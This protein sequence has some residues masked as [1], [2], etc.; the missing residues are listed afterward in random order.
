MK[1]FIIIFIVGIF[2][3]AFIVGKCNN[4]DMEEVS[5]EVVE[6]VQDKNQEIDI[7]ETVVD[8]PKDREQSVFLDSTVSDNPRNL[9]S[10]PEQILV[11]KGYCT[12]YNNETK[13]PNWVAWHL[14]REHTDGQFS[15]NGVPYYAEDGT[16]YGIGNITAEI[17]K[18]GYF[19]DLEAKEPRQQLSDWTREYNMS[20]GHMCPAGDN[21]WDKVAMNQSF[22]LTN[23]CP[24]DEKLN[25]GGWQK[26]EEKCRSWANR[27]GE[28]YIVAGPIFN[29]PISRTIGEG[30]IA[31]PDAFF[32][33]VLCIE[34]FPKA[35]GFIYKNDSSSQSIKDCVCSVDVVEE[36]VG[37]DFFSSLPD[38]IEETIES[39]SDLGQW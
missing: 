9:R 32:K 37:F 35:I 36:L 16:V 34:G 2:L 17:C 27:F 25:G 14:S 22:L 6:L 3:L 5:E 21:K 10:Y 23:M 31:V 28:I 7:K 4:D 13:C 26:L 8:V 15:R 33:V 11:R 1:R 39:E 12:S 30:Q 38:K 18:N 24:Q 29:E 20:H 19:V